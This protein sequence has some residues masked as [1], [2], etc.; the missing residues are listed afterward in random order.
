MRCAIAMLSA[1]WAALADE[2]VRNVLH[3]QQQDLY[4]RMMACEERCRQLAQFRKWLAG[5]CDKEKNDSLVLKLAI[6]PKEWNAYSDQLIQDHFLQFEKEVLPEKYVTKR[7]IMQW[8]SRQ[9]P[10]WRCD[11]K[12]VQRC[13]KELFPG[14]E[15]AQHVLLCHFSELGYSTFDS[16]EPETDSDNSDD[17]DDNSDDDDD[18]D[19]DDIVMMC[20]D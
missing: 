11:A 15:P 8:I 5:N 16:K 4:G 14:A 2:E 12:E 1:N 3:D 19:S 20:L 7:K 6:D 17:G 9:A 10:D 13:S 18:D